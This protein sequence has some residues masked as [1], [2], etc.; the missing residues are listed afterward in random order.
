MLTFYT[1]I[2][3]TEEDKVTFEYIYHSYH[4]QMLS[5]AK[6]VLRVHED[7]EDALQE[8]LL[9]IAKYIRSVPTNPKTQRAYV[10]TVA[11]NAAITM[12]TDCRQREMFVEITELD[13]PS[14][15]DPFDEVVNKQSYDNV[16]KLLLSLPIQYREVMMF[17]YVMNIPVK[18]IASALFRNEA[19]VKQQITRGKRLFYELYQKENA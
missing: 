16:L 7:A 19:T 3:E 18:E 14:G 2:I 12:L 1:S 13:L 11:R 8:A 9:K 17:R 6:G 4:K 5:I 10:F 15:P